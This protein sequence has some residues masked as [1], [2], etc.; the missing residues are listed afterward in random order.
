MRISKAYKLENLV[1][2]MNTH[3]LANICIENNTAVACD[4]KVMA[5]VPLKEF[6]PNETGCISPEILV[7]A[8]KASVKSIKESDIFLTDKEERLIDGLTRPRPSSEYPKYKEVIPID[9]P[10]IT[11]SF[12]IKLLDKLAKA[13]NSD[14]LVLEIINPRKAIRVYPA[15]KGNEAFGLLM[16]IDI[17][18]VEY[19]SE[20]LNE[21]IVV[22][23]KPQPPEEE[24]ENEETLEENEEINEVFE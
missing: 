20:T 23:D 2:E 15:N 19:K 6:E 7:A 11:V 9:E 24:K 8:R 13:I 18:M 16:P 5:I 3:G 17:N 4:G 22:M 21:K 10:Q 1:D 14:R 12:D